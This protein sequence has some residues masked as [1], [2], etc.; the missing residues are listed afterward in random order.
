VSSP[1]NSTTDDRTTYYNEIAGSSRERLGALSDGI[2][3]V[4]M[5]LLV[6]TLAVPTAQEVRDSGS[7]GGA[8]VHLVPNIV[9][10]VMSFLTLGIF[11]VGQ[12][13]QLSQLERSDRDYTW[14]MLAFLLFVT[15]VPFSTM[16]LAAFYRSQLALVEY[17]FNV[18]ILGGAILAG[19]EYAGHQHFF[20][21]ARQATIL[22]AIRMRIYSAQGLYLV[23]TALCLIDTR[24][25]IGVIV[26]LQLNYAIA[27]RIAF[28]RRL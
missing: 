3:G 18:A 4:A 28:L 27:P 14:I 6:L 25:S 9:T 2:F 13:T 7:L 5:T 8:L 19:A 23:A 17:W 20:P 15:F 16:L 26:L 1:D 10:Y 21:A 11:W 12:Q 24:I 22:R